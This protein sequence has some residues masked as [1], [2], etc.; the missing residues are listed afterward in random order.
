MSSNVKLSTLA[1]NALLDAITTKLGSACLIDIYSGT[2]PAGP[3]TAVTSQVKL[4]TLTGGTPFAPGASGGVLTAGAVANG[5]GS[6]GASTGTV[7]TWFRCST[8]GGTPELD[9]TVA[10]A[11]AD[12]NINN[13]SIATG[14]TVSISS[15]TI[16]APNA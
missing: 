16:T 13:T 4:A 14:Q 7:A 3:D 8:S 11:G 15:F 1:R 6:V 5:T 10:A 9:G 12:M 2:Q